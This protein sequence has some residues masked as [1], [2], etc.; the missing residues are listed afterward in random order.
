MLH[1]SACAPTA[2]RPM[3]SFTVLTI[4][5]ESTIILLRRKRCVDNLI[6]KC[7]PCPDNQLPAPNEERSSISLANSARHS[8]MYRP[9]DAMD[10]PQPASGWLC[11]HGDSARDGQC[12]NWLCR[13]NYPAPWWNLWQVWY[14]SNERVPNDGPLYFSWYGHWP[15]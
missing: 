6:C 1:A 3:K 2:L 8:C 11:L 4:S 7:D 14:C 5:L 13:G 10:Y 12:R 15:T 9:V